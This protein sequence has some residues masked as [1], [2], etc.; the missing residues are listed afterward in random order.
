MLKQFLLEI[1]AERE[2]CLGCAPFK[3]LFALR[4]DL[5]KCTEQYKN[6]VLSLK[7]KE[8]L[9]LPSVCSHSQS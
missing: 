7:R 5:H 8:L 2:I 4:P 1:G 9:N 3:D 6:R